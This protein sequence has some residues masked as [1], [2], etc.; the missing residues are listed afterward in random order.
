M[1]RRALAAVVAALASVAPHVQADDA[2]QRVE[3]TGSAIKRNDAEGALPVQVLRRVDI[4]RSGATWTTDL[5]QRLPALQGGFRESGAI[6]IESHGFSSVA[7]HNLGDARTLVLLNGHRLASFGGQSL[8]G[9]GAAV[10]LS[11]IPLAAIERVEIL[12]DGASALYG[13]DAIAGVVNVI[14]RRDSTAREVTIGVSA[15]RGGAREKRA[16]ATLGFGS[17]ADDGFS[18]M[19]T[20]AHDERSALA[21]T[22]RSYAASG[23]VEFDVDGK[24]YRKRHSSIPSIPANAV[25]DQGRL[26]SPYALTRGGCPPRTFRI[27]QPHADGSGRADDYCGYDF[28]GDIEIYPARKR[29]SVLASV[30]RRI[31]DAE[32]SAE[33]LLTRTRSIARTAPVAGQIAVPAGS[34]L[35]TQYLLPI[36]INGDSLAF[37]RFHD[38]GPRQSID[39]NDFFDLAIGV[40]GY[41]RGWDYAATLARSKSASAGDIAGYP[42]ALAVRRLSAGGLLDPFVGPGRQS[43]AAQAALAAAGYRGDWSGGTSILDTVQWRATRELGAIAARPVLLAL[44]IEFH[45]ERFRSAPSPFA[46]GLLA[47]PVRGTLCDPASADPALACD[48]RFGDAALSVPYAAA[49]HSAGLFGE[50]VTPLRERLELTTSLRADRYSDFGQATTAKAALRYTPTDR[51]L[52]RASIGTGFRAPSVPQAAAPPQPFGVTSNAYPC[53]PELAR[54]AASLNAVC[55]SGVDAYGVVAG[56]NPALQPE[57]SR[58]ASVGVRFEPNRSLAV[59]V[60]LWHVRIRD[61][62]GQ[63]TEQQVFADPLGYPDAWTTRTDAGTGVTRLALKAGNR[64]L[65]KSTSTGL[66]IDVATRLPIGGG[67][68]SSSFTMTYMLGEKR[69]LEPGGPYDSAIGNFAELGVVTFRWQGRWTNTVSVGDWAHTLALNF[70]SGYL[71]QATQVERLAADGSVAGIETIRLPVRHTFT[72]DWQTRWTPRKDITVTLGAT[73]LL[74]A[75]P[76]LSISIGGVGRGQ[77]FGY[78]DRYDDP[79]GRTWYASLGY[80]F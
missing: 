30:T 36:G 26:V 16:S 65:G 53:T 47:D 32:W 24:R 60:D 50:L 6:G 34:T 35:H 41:A 51:L 64:N 42:G 1:K 69:Q 45:K 19:L 12:T 15:P 46:R 11:A 54:M 3:V 33:G 23:S 27:V 62:F 14:T 10:D 74:D 5:L 7:I 40:K 17:L 31:G 22:A 75:K 68:W 44:G 2:V 8:D 49:R 73:N 76:P 59:G 63:L 38:L 39:T 72:L 21:A 71:D 56:G 52:L 4:E 13:A 77:P 37:Y 9:A 78:D 80:A 70:R 61:A 67:V 29:D 18:A 58:Q 55:R 43:A 66:D 25:D 79:R 20:L 28:I 57:K 48:Q